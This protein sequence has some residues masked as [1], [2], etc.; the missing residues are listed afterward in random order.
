[1]KLRLVHA[2]RVIADVDAPVWLERGDELCLDY[3]EY[4]ERYEVQHRRMVIGAAVV[5]QA[6]VTLE[7]EIVP[8]R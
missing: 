3:D 4:T 7:L 1:M 5:G 6:P 8:R 2:D